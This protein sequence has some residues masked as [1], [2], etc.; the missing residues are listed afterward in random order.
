MEFMENRWFLTVHK[1]YQNYHLP[2]FADIININ[3][4]KGADFPPKLNINAPMVYPV[5]TPSASLPKIIPMYLLR[6]LSS[7]ENFS[8]QILIAVILINLIVQNI[9][10]LHLFNIQTEIKIKYAPQTDTI[11][12]AIPCKLLATVS[13]KKLLP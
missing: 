8:A 11:T 1:R 7:L 6:I 12:E 2:V 3:T 10:T 9:I 5:S 4:T 13:I